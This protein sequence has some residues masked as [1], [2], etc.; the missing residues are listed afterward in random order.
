M[1]LSN[2]FFWISRDIQRC[3]VIS[4][5]PEGRYSLLQAF[6]ITVTDSQIFASLP[7]L[8]YVYR[9]AYSFNMDMQTRQLYSYCVLTPF[10]KQAQSQARSLVVRS[11]GRTPLTS[12]S[13]QPII[14]KVIYRGLK[15]H[16]GIF[17]KTMRKLRRASK[18]T[19]RTESRFL[20]QNYADILFFRKKIEFSQTEVFHYAELRRPKFSLRRITQNYAGPMFI[21]RKIFRVKGTYSSLVY[22]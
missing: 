5:E 21:T 8:V 10:K 13:T 11:F 1:Q 19:L 16:S 15:A 9:L 6:T 22:R 2:A 18:K 3:L 17:R 4:N 14:R 20:T 7:G 12:R